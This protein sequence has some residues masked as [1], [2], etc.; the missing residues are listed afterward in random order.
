MSRGFKRSTREKRPLKRG[1]IMMMMVIMMV[2]VMI[3]MMIIIN[4]NKTHVIIFFNFSFRIK[5]SKQSDCHC[6]S[7]HFNSR[8]LIHQLM[9]F[10]I[11]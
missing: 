11:Q 5:A 7:V 2:V 3:M 8:N 10:Y 1:K 9:H 4:N 6:F